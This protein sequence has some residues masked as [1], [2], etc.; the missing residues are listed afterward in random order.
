M[1]PRELAH[2]LRTTADRLESTSSFMWGHMGACNCGHLAQTV[3]GLTGAEIHRAALAREG[4]WERQANEYCPTSGLLV[5]HILAA[6][7]AMGF[8]RADVRHLERLSDPRVLARVGRPLRFNRRQDAID[9]LRAWAELVS[10][11]GV[12][13]VTIPVSGEAAGRACN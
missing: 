3:T 4:E 12:S 8:T 11:S 5:D 7:F 2:A 9:Y 13:D 10:P 6:M 1:D